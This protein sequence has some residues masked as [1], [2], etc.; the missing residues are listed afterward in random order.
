[1]EASLL[2][3]IP[4]VERVLQ[5]ALAQALAAEFGRE[6]VTEAVRSVQEDLRTRLREGQSV[7]E[8]SLSPEAIA[9]EAALWLHAQ[10]APRLRRVINATGTVIHTNLGRALLG[11]AVAEYLA[12]SSRHYVALEYDLEAGQRGH[13]DAIV[14]P[15]LQRLT[16]G[17]AATVVN[18]NAAAV[19]LCLNT[20]AKGK[21]V[22]VSRGELIEI[23]GSFRIPEVMAASGALLRE[24]G[25]TNRTHLRDYREAIN[26]N[27]ALLLK[28]HPSNYRILGFTAEVPMEDIVALGREFHLPTMEDLGSGALVD[29]RAFGLPYEPVVR[30][31][32][33]LGVDLVTFSGDKLLM[34][35]QAGIIV[36]RRALIE[37]IRR[38]PLM[39]VVRVGRLILAALEATLRLYLHP[40]RLAEHLPPL[41]MLTRPAEEVKEQAE[42]LRARLA[43]MLRGKATVAV[44]PTV[45]EIGSGALPLE[46]VPSWALTLRPHQ[47]SAERLAAALRRHS[48]PI[49]GRLQDQRLFLDLRTLDQEEMVEIERALRQ[50][51]EG[52]LG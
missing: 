21:E 37:R 22:I 39:R 45:S 17:E 48:P 2:R 1:M 26:E 16:G 11:R 20:L 42:A 46:G 7:G 43:P 41:A 49:L 28:V 6:W 24:V 51:K 27:T 4:S 35:P 32:V 50:W 12:E 29:L 34:G 5:T 40:Q 25:T 36:G 19:F 13:R 9:Q 23:G 38:N 14:E 52:E 30:D 18:N 10:F 31:R 33:A 8:T 3:G 15:L 47:V 44:E